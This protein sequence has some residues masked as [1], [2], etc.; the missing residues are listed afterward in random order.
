[1]FFIF[2]ISNKRKELDFNQTV[3][4]SNC[5]NYGRYKAFMTYSYFSLFFIQIIKWN[6]KYYIKSTCCG[7][8][9]Y[10]DEDIGK[11]IDRGEDV[12]IEESDLDPI[13]VNKKN[14]CTNCGYPVESGFQ[15]CPKCGE[16]V[17]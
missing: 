12:I 4:C 15:Y 5:G 17:D 2:G 8:T 6:K 16:R 7:S 3:V 10:L 14:V 13:K 1:M 9:Y 11:R